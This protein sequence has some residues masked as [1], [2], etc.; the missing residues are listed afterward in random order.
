MEQD[1]KK[2]QGC[3]TKVNVPVLFAKHT[4][5]YAERLE[6]LFGS[7]LQLAKCSWFIFVREQ[8]SLGGDIVQI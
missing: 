3:E 1:L 8:N 7:A 6:I 2:S 5:V 4:S